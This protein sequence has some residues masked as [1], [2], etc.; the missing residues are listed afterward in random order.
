MQT[1]LLAVGGVVGSMFPS[2]A[3]LAAF[4]QPLTG[5]GSPRLLN[6]PDVAIARIS[7]LSVSS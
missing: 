2:A 6:P 4:T 7:W 1:L 3:T 5:D